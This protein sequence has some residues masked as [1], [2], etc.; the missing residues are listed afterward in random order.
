MLTE[1]HLSMEATDRRPSTQRAYGLAVCQ[2]VRGL[3]DP[4]SSRA[5]QSGV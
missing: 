3:L 1:T 5:R 2:R 4:K